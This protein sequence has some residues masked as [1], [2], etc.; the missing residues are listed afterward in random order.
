MGGRVRL[1]EL[2]VKEL[3]QLQ[4]EGLFREIRSI[5]QS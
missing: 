2:T 4:A 1:E 3:L 5:I